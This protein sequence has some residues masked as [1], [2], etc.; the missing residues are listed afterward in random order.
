MIISQIPCSTRTTTTTAVWAVTSD[1]DNING[2]ASAV[3]DDTKESTNWLE[4]WALEGSKKIASLDI[5]ERTQRALLAEMCEDEIYQLTIE[6]EQLQ[7]ETTGEIWNMDRAKEIALQSR[8]LQQQYKDLV[9]GDPSSV[10]TTL[11]S[12]KEDQ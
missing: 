5:T 2:N 11:L 7:D 1:D 9:S 3:D 6:L 10:L 4:T 12:L 8:S